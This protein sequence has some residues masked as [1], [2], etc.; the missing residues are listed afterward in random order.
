MKIIVI[1]DVHCRNFYK[2]VLNIKDCQIIF[3]GDYMDPYLEDGF[4]NENGIN[5]LHEIIDFAR[6][7]SNVHLLVGNH[8]CSWIWSRLG[9]ERT[10]IKYYDEL[11]N[12]Y[13][14]NIDLFKPFI[15]FDNTLFLH[16]GI[17]KG[18][19]NSLNVDNILDYIDKEFK[20]ELEHEL[21][22]NL[23]SPIFNIGYIRGGYSRYG[24]PFWSDIR[25]MENPFEDV[26]QIF[27]H[28]Q[29]TQTGSFIDVTSA[30]KFSGASAYCCDSRAIFIWENNKLTKYEE[31]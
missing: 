13:R 29:L 22:P 16:A 6:N 21:H 30:R 10:P 7:N 4:S 25:E 2:P 26:I 23:N 24:G 9:W 18:W 31:N 15:K 27:S 11:H 8:D 17:S 12:I 1:P 20:L 28:T 5:N 3:L 19:L 14:S